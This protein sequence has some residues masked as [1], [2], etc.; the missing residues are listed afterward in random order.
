[1][2]LPHVPL[3]TETIEVAGEK[4]ELR[5]L[6]RAEVLRFQSLGSDYDKAETFFVAQGTGFSEEEVKA[7]REQTPARVVDEL[8]EAIARLTG[9]GDDTFQDD[10]PRSSAGRD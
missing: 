8:V 9:L 5:A 7:W 10:G 2:G 6:S 3:P 4:L 1:M